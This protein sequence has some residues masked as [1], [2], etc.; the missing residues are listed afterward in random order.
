MTKSVF[1]VVLIAMAALCFS[2]TFAEESKF[3]TI[4]A[5]ILEVEELKEPLG[6]AILTA[7]DLTSGET[8]RLFADPSLS[9]FQSGDE[10]LDP[11]DVLGGS[12]AT[13]IYRES[14]KR[15]LPEII[16]ATVSG[17]YY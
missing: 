6:S 4:E 5:E 11:G 14:S 7:K 10:K 2:Q 13:I 15:D 1:I 3:K 8:I 16:F 12:K 9:L 17:S